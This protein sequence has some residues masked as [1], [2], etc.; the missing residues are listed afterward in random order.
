MAAIDLCPI[1]DA[2]YEH[3]CVKKT[4]SCLAVIDPS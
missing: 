3:P 2:V 4:T 1:I